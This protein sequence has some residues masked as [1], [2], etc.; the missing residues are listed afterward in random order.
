MRNLACTF[1][2]NGIPKRICLKKIAKER[3]FRVTVEGVQMEY[4]LTD[5]DHVKPLSDSELPDD[6]LLPHI[7]W[8]IRHYFQNTKQLI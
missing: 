7:E 5:E 8:M 2:V 4:F 3:K 6:S 1:K